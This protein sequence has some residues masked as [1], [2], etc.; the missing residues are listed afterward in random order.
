MQ[1]QSLSDGEVFIHVNK[2][3]DATGKSAQISSVILIKATPKAIWAVLTDCARAPTYVPGLKKCEILEK[4]PD[5]LWDIRRHTSKI[6]PFLPK[7]K[8]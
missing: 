1:L 2:V 3:V 4:S 8:S 6:S 7:I 5:G